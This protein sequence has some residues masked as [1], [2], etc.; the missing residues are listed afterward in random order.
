MAIICM[1]SVCACLVLHPSVEDACSSF[2]K[3]VYQMNRSWSILCW[4]VRGINSADKWLAI[5]NKIE[6]SNCEIFCFQETKKEIFDSAFIRNFAPRRFDKFIFAPSAGASGGI[7]VAWNGSL[8]DGTVVAVQ[9]FAITVSFSSRMDMNV[10]NLSTVYGPCTEPDRTTFI[11][12][13]R[14]LDIP[15]DYNWILMGDFNFYRSLSDRNREGGNF[16]D[17]QRF[18]EVIDHLG[19]V[20]LPLKG[21][22]FTWSNMQS[23]PLLEQLDWFFTSVNWTSDFPN[24][25]VNPLARPTSDHVPCKVSIETKIPRANVFRFENFWASHSTFLSTVQSSWNQ[26]TRNGNNIVAVL[27]GKFKRLRHD[28]KNWSKNLSNL[29]LLIEN[30]KK[31][32][33]YLDTVEEYRNLFNSEWNTRNIIKVQLNN[34]LEQ[35]NSYWKQRNT[36]NR[37][38]HGDECTK[39]FH[40]MATVSYRRNL[41]AQVQ[42]DYGVSLLHHD[43]K[44]N[45]FWCH[46]KNRMGLSNQVEMA[47]DLNSLVSLTGDV[48]WSSLDSPFSVTEIDSIVKHMPSDKA[49]GPDGFNGVFIKKCWQ[50]IKEDVY[51]LFS[52]F[53]ENRANIAPINSSYIVLVPKNSSPMTASDFRPIS[54]LNCCVKMLTKLLA[55]RMQRM[56]LKII[57]K[58]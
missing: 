26:P 16:Q 5:R 23:T 55:D 21:R 20:E 43:D 53:F 36:I 24:T 38:K 41:I 30:C 32:I 44:A 12:W 46:F 50:I 49:P 58:N 54:L 18:N 39:Y 35:Q 9:S 33:L 48:D 45:F 31:V 52:E 51:K 15:D 29:K 7:L 13:L 56:I 28:L 17:T 37:I 4:N 10:W 57:H 8:F 2:S 34:L 27:S 11:D 6:E 47:F 1:M 22:A 40:S 25:M 42:D 14:S 19:L 3:I